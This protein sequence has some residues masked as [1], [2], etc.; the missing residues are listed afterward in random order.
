MTDK[1][2]TQDIIDALVQKHS[3]N[4]KDATAFVKEVFLLIEHALEKDG[5]VKLKGLGTFKIIKVDTRESVNVNTGDRFT[6]QG[7]SKIAFV[8]D[9]DL[10]EL[11]N[12]PF[13][14][15]DTV[16]LDDLGESNNVPTVVEQS[17]DAAIPSDN[18]IQETIAI[19]E[20]P[21]MQIEDS[22]EKNKDN[23]NN[24]EKGKGKNKKK[25]YTYLTIGAIVATLCGIILYLSVPNNDNKPEVTIHPKA[26]IAQTLP[27]SLAIDTIN[28]QPADTIKAAIP[29][30]AQPISKQERIAEDLRILNNTDP[31]HPDS[32]N[33]II[34]GT[35]TTYSIKKGETLTKVALRFYGTK[36]LWPY[37]LKHNS[38]K[39]KS[40]GMV[41]SGMV[42]AIP[43]LKKKNE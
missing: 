32:I 24:D 28:P 10:R 4:K 34:I 41:T 2:N 33:Y 30:K 7:H 38:K 11:L 13:A 39:I 1:L 25:V 3:M 27:E 14:H 17:L 21:P 16:I 42:L 37:I 26:P 8:P 20:E 5:M 15:L 43:E 18:D 12:K 36:D 22:D 29:V 19:K 40:P 23:E 35:K 31:V 6:I 9:A